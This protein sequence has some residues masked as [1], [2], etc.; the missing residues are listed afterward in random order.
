MKVLFVTGI[1]L[2]ALFS[3]AQY[4]VDSMCG[5]KVNLDKEGKLLARY[6]PQIP[7][8]AY[9]IAVKLAVD[10]LKSCP[11]SPKNNL[12]LYLTHCSMYRDGKGGYVGSD[13][14]HN[15]IVVNGG[16]VQSLAIDWRNY[17]GDESL[18]AIA[19]QALDHQI[20]FGTTPANWEWASV[21]YASSDAGAIIYQG[22]SRFDTAKTDENRGRGDGSFVLECD[23]I[24]EM[25]IHYVKFYQITGE[26][27]YLTAALLCADALAKHVRKSDNGAGG[28]DWKKLAITSPWPFRVRAENGEILEDY[29]SHVVENL[30]LLDELVRI[31][32]R[33]KLP[34][35]KARAYQNASG[36]AW[37]WLYSAEGPIKTAIWKGYFEDIRFDPINLNRV[38]NSPMEFARYLVKYPVHDKEISTTVPALIWWVKN[39]FGEKGMNAINEQTGCY[40]PMGSHT[41]RYASINALWYEHTGDKWFKEEAYRFFNHASYMAEPDGVVQTG[42]NWGAEIWF[43]DG[44]TDYIRHFMEGLAA[45]P[46]WAP[47]G[48][49]HL[50]KSSSVVQKINYGSRRISYQAYD[51]DANEV[52]RLASKPVA[53]TVGGTAV[54]ETKSTTAEGW[55]WEPLSAGGVL[56]IHHK[57]AGAVSIALGSKKA[58]VAKAN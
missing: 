3:K 13:W 22:A 17:S 5:A 41:S 43:S 38:N 4:K 29:T 26:E 11:L 58:A 10:F 27:K 36:V 56:R 23:K 39:T 25:G 14:P 15:P 48:K 16:L 30:R 9:T 28:L 7:G 42:H 51:A 52:L 35:E 32:D 31:K 1:L 8:A 34:D 49:N 2:L 12:P 20:E 54:K 24:G 33:I 18:V 19:R 37:G 57:S 53:I 45:V 44:Y 40:L 21:P 46:E 47:A 55:T 6:E 50:L